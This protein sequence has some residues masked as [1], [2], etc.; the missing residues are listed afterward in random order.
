MKTVVTH[1]GS[2]HRDEF[3]SCCL[4]IA[5]GKVDCIQR[6]DCTEEDLTASTYND[7]HVIVLDQGGRHEPEL[8]NFDHHQFPREADPACSI[9]LILTHIGINAEKAR[10]IWDWLEF[11]ELLDSKG[12]FATAEK[13]GSTPE[14]I[15][16]GVSPIETTVLQWFEEINVL[17]SPEHSV[18][19]FE[20][21]DASL[22]V[23]MERIGREKLDYLNEVVERHAFLDA[24]AK[25]VEVDGL[26]V[27]DATCVPRDE[28]PVM[29]LESW[30]QTNGRIRREFPGDTVAVTVTQDDRGHGVCLYRRN[31]DPRIDFSALEGKTDVE[32][33]HKGGFVAKLKRLDSQSPAGSYLKWKPFVQQS[34]V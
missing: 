5:A 30:I 25:I 19:G 6:R 2:A 8:L 31:D 21:P 4:L 18:A 10:S 28:N 26:V 32:F 11:S 24:N 29:G 34:I 22:Y 20:S 12:P 27:V 16:A 1:P 23:L 13:L 14:A 15:F 9:T 3:L 33:A 17:S 7:P